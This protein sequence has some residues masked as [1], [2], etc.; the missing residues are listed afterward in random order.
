MTNEHIVTV[1]MQAVRDA[2]DRGK[3]D[4]RMLDIEDVLTLLAMNGEGQAMRMLKRELGYQAPGHVCAMT[5]GECAECG[6]TS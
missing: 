2:Y 4:G 3:A 6:A 5:D 1:A